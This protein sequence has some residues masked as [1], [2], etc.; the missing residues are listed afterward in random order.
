[1][2]TPRIVVS[3]FTIIVIGMLAGCGRSD[4]S[5]P[6]S[7]VAAKVNDEDITVHQINNMLARAGGMSQ[8]QAKVMS[9][10]VLEGLIDQQLLLQ[11]ATEAKLD[12][13]ATIMSAIEAARRQILARAY[14]ERKAADALK[15]TAEEISKY[16]AERPE[17]FAQRRIYR[18]QEFVTVVTPEQLQSLQAQLAKTKNLND[19][20][21]WMKSQGIPFSGN[22]SIRAAEQLPMD[23]LPRFQKMKTGEITV[24][25]VPS[26]TLVVQLVAIQEAPLSEKE[27]APLIERAL[28]NQ[29]RAELAAAEVKQLRAAAKVEYVGDY[30]KVAVPAADAK[31]TPPSSPN[32]EEK[33]DNSAIDKGLGG[34]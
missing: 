30:S 8:E 29:R 23:Q 17:L 4:G 1:M 9:Q 21:A 2:N 33:Q 19:A 11:K 34:L 12:R 27:A 26:R 13:D 6:A 24:F 15:P 32:Q 3:I 16:Y 28:L 7:Q 31:A 18:F 10:Q 25:S 5:K 22:F 20:A 14:I